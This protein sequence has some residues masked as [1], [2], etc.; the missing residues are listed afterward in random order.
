MKCHKIFRIL[1]D[2]IV[3]FCTSLHSKFQ[4]R[5]LLKLKS[6]ERRLVRME[7]DVNFSQSRF[8]NLEWSE[9][10]KCTIISA[11]V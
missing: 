10:L 8:W 3:H 4:I 1:S 11:V 6:A 9:V 5:D 2:I 7:A